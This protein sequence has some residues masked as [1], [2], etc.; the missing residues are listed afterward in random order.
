MD[1][2]RRADDTAPVTVD[3]LHLGRPRAIAAHLMG[4]VIVDPGAERTIDRV[5]EALDGRAPHAVLLTHIHFDHAGAAGALVRRF[6]QL[7][8]WVHER[9]ARHLADPARLVSS[10]RRI[11]GDAFDTLWGSVT[12]VPEGNLRVVHGGERIG[13]WEVAYTPGHA[14]HHVAYLHAPTRTA[15]TGDLTGI[16]MGTGPAF[17]PTPAPD[18][19]PPLWHASLHTLAAWKPERLAFSHFGQTTD[20]DAHLAMLH[21][22]LD[23]FVDAA[24]STDAAG[25]AAWIRAWLTA[26]GAGDAI[27]DYYW[28]SPFEG[29]WGGLD[30]YRRRAAPSA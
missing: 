29:M 13:P 23:A 4:D 6:P 1:A 14:Q 9:G 3:L 16:R 5:L 18:I 22:S 21:A 24:A 20:V 28:A 11:Y 12:P 10:A 27:D 17:P 25:L 2:V 19:D 8:V 30:R 7:E 15:F 26:E